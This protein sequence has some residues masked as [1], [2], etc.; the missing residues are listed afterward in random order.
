MAERC[1]DDCPFEARI[2]DLDLKV[3][4][5]NGESLLTRTRTLEGTVGRIEKVVLGDGESNG[6]QTHMIEFRTGQRI[7]MWLLTAGIGIG[8]FIVSLVGFW[9]AHF[10]RVH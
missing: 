5:G 3:F 4:R 8:I 1:A 9:M 7:I 10:E 6:L 2:D